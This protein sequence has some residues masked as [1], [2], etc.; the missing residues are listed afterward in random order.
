MVLTL[1][2]NWGTVAADPSPL[3]GQNGQI[4]VEEGA[5]SIDTGSLR[6]HNRPTLSIFLI[7]RLTE[8]FGYEDLIY[9]SVNFTYIFCTFTYSF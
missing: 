6:L 8:F 1:D 2:R 7:P 9:K 3:K 5:E 4:C